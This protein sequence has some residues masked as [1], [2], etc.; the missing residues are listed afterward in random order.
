MKKQYYVYMLTNYKKTVLYTGVTSDLTRRVW[1]HKNKAIE[2]FTN[3]YNV[4]KLVYYEY[5]EN[6]TSAITREK[7]IKNL[8][9][10]K[11]D[12]LIND[13]NPAWEDLYLKILSGFALQDDGEGEKV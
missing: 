11:K 2:G 9:R 7:S 6:P 4:D 1:Q 12:K 10:R 3:K 8:V 5:T 13:F